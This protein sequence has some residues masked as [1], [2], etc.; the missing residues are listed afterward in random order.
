MGNVGS[1]IKFKASLEKPFKVY[2]SDFDGNGTFDVVLS[3]EYKGTYVPSRGKE[4]STQ[5]MPFISEKFETYSDFANA[6]LEDVYGDALQDAYQGE[7]TNFSSVL[8]LNNGDGT[9]KKVTLPSMAQTFPILACEFFDVNKDGFEDAVLVGNIYNTEAET[10][11]LDN[12]YG[13]VLLSN[14][15]NGY[16]PVSANESGFYHKGNTKSV[17]MV[18]HGATGKVFLI[19]GVNNTNTV[20]F[21]IK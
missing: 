18:E 2:G 12:G 4:C 20:V 17:V 13:L 16:L 10:P 15:R 8:L 1:N 21:E 5:Q 7:V 11:R 19:E 14:G 9:F 3:N 6:S